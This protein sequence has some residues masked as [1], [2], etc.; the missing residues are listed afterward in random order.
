[1]VDKFSLNEDAVVALKVDVV[2][3]CGHIM[4]P[5]AKETCTTNYQ[6]QRDIEFKTKRTNI[7]RK[8]TSIGSEASGEQSAVSD[9]AKAGAMQ[10]GITGASQLITGFFSLKAAGEYNKAAAELQAAQNAA[11]P[12]PSFDPLPDA[13]ANPQNNPFNQPSIA[14]DSGANGNLNTSSGIP[15]QNPGF[16]S[17][18]PGASGA[19][20]QPG[21]FQVGSGDGPAA[22]GLGGSGSV[23]GA[24]GTSA[25]TPEKEVGSSLAMQEGARTFLEGGGSKNNG[26]ARA[27]ASADGG[28]GMNGLADLFNKMFPPD[29]ASKNHQGIDQASKYRNLASDNGSILGKEVNIFG[30]IHDRYQDKRKSGAVGI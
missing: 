28:S 16:N 14:A 11:L 23:G 2:R 17:A 26:V 10:S 1:V 12:A 5:A 20:P 3:E 15:L 19:A 8:A 18:D 27:P 25:A 4:D 6:K 24:G 30:R 22:K 7:A 29:E 13:T 9:K 21:G